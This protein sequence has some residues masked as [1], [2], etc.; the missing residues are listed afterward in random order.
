MGLQNITLQQT[1]QSKT[2]RCVYFVMY[3]KSQCY[4]WAGH[5]DNNTWRAMT[6]SRIVYDIIRFKLGLML[7]MTEISCAVCHIRRIIESLTHWVR[8]MH[9]CVSKLTIIGWDN[10]LSPGRRQAIIWTIDAILL[11]EPLGTKFNEILIEIHFHSRKCIWQCRLWND[12]HF[13]WA[14]M[15]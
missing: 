14:S 10:G 11:T 6:K 3:G 1:E 9:I 12:S 8:V 13:V 4:P 5:L 15:C 2:K 7:P